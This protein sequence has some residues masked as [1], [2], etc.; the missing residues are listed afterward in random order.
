MDLSSTGKEIPSFIGTT[1]RSALAHKGRGITHRA[2]QGPLPNQAEVN[3]GLAAS[4][5]ICAF[6]AEPDGTWRSPRSISLDSER[7]SVTELRASP[8]ACASQSQR[9]ASR[10]I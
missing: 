5:T 2:G 3:S 1:N 7:A 4:I 10:P 9:S 6:S 8:K